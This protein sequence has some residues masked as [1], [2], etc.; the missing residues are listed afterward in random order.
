MFETE[1]MAELCVKQ[2]LIE[3][4]I[5]IFRRLAESAADERSR[6][7]YEARLSELAH[8]PGVAPLE[9]PGLRI[10]E[11]GE[12]VQIEWRLPKHVASPALELLLLRHGPDGIVADRRK[13]A[14]PAPSGTM[15]V[16]APGLQHARAAAG[17]AEGDVFVPMV[18]C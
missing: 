10:T 11:R 16:P 6:R 9:T 4:A 18:R 5:D 3:Q 17:R 15:S 13:L 8:G 7:R 1:T 12:A 2:G 14:L